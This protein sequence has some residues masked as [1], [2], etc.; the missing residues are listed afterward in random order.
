LPEI[1]RLVG[2]AIA[3]KTRKLLPD[4]CHAIASQSVD[5]RAWHRRALA[6]QDRMATIASGDPGVVL[7]DV[8]R[9][10]AEKLGTAVKGNARAEELIHFVLSAEYL[11]LR[12]GLGL[13]GAS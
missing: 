2:K 7:S 12:R 5:A 4:V 9:V 3:R 6:S 10:P 8:L 1:E 13:E 11:E